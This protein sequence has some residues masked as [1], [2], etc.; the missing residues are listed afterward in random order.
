MTTVCLRRLELSTYHASV[1][2]HSIIDLLCTY[3]IYFIDIILSDKY[4]RVILNIIA[5]FSECGEIILELQLLTRDY[6]YI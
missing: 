2:T 5:S 1:Q 4:Y 6:T 3:L